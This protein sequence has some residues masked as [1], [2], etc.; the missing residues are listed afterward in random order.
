MLAWVVLATFV[1]FNEPGFPRIDVG[2]LPA[3]DE[4]DETRSVPELIDALKP[5]AILVWRHGSAFPADFWPAFMKFLDAGGS[6]LYLGG[7]P[8]TRFVVGEPGSRIVQARSVAGLKALRLNQC[9]R[10]SAA[11]GTRELTADGRDIWPMFG[12]GLETDEFQPGSWVAVLEPRLCETRDFDDEDGT[13]GSRD[14]AL[15]PLVSL[16]RRGEAFSDATLAY[17]IDRLRGRWAG[18]RWTFWLASEP[19]GMLTMKLLTLAAAQAPVD[20]RIDPILG[21]F[22]PDEHP[23]FIV[24]LHLS[25]KSLDD[26]VPVSR[27]RVSVEGDSEEA[28]AERQEIE[29]RGR[30]A[31]AQIPVGVALR[32]GLAHVSAVLDGK[33]VAHTAFWVFD[34][35]LFESGDK[36]EFDNYTLRRS[37]KPEPIIGTTVMSQTVHRKFLF[38]PN[39]AVWDDTFRELAELKINMV[40]TGVWTGYRKISLDPGVVDESF[41]RALEAYYLSARKHGIP[42]MFTFFAFVPPAFGGENP[43]FDPRAIEGQRAYVAAIAGRFAGAKEIMWDLINEPSFSSPKHLWK[44]RPN[45][46]EF[47]KRAFLAWLEKK[48][49]PPLGAAGSERPGSG[50][51]SEPGAPST[52]VTSNRPAVA[53]PPVSSPISNGTP[54]LGAAGSE[55][56]G[57]GGLSEPGAPSTGVTSNRPAVASPPVSSPISNGTPPLG[58]AGSERPGSGGLSEPGAPSTGVTS[59]RPAVASPPVSSPISNGTPPLGAAGS[60][61]PGSGGL[62]EPGAPSTGVTSNRPAV[63]SPP[64][65]SPIS[66]GTPPLGAAGSER[67]G[68]GGLSEPGA[69]STGVTSNRP[70]VASP[71]V[72]SPTSNIT[73]PLGAAGSDRLRSDSTS[74]NRTVGWEDEVR[75]RW[76]LAPGEPIGLPTPD[77]FEDR[78]VF[79]DNHPYR[80]ADYVWF[81]Q[82]A[83]ADWCRQMTAAIRD[84]GSIAPITVGQDEGGL[85]QRPGPLFHHEAVDFTSMHTWWNNDALLWDAVAAKARGKALIVSETGVMQRELLSG[86][87]LRQ[88]EDSARLLSRKLALAFAGGAG[89]VIQ[90]CYDV[91]PYM[92]SDN[93]VAIGLRRVDGSYKPEHRVLRD[94][95][96]FV[97][98]NKQ[99]FDAPQE[100]RIAIVIPTAEQFS[101]RDDATRAT[102]RAADLLVREMGQNVRLVPEPRLA[103]DLDSP[104]VVVLPACRGI[105]EAGWTAILT[106]ARRGAR[107][108]CSGWFETDEVGRPARRLGLGPP[109]LIGQTHGVPYVAG[110]PFG[111]RWYPLAT[112]E[113]WFVPPENTPVTGRW[114]LGEPGLDVYHTREPIEWANLNA[115]QMVAYWDAI[116][117]AGLK[118]GRPPPAGVGV[119]RVEFAAATLLVAVNESDGVAHVEAESQGGELELRPG[120]ARLAILERESGRIIDATSP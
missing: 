116:A 15:V 19:P 78:N 54:P 119:Y 117:A 47:E 2:E 45:G 10:V 29:L 16:L 20:L 82:E 5:D 18:G 66:N 46:D 76:R 27:I 105:S 112:M 62:S 40:R 53:S 65:S 56:P 73:P 26:S 94:F 107:V 32:P 72:S 13:A 83:F 43:Y 68:S 57:S 6:F 70:A 113:S 50:G 44:C 84:A 37:G 39:A 48:F 99:Y 3:I 28:A 69:P 11:G 104:D 8:F 80:A 81:A 100:P 115:S 92:A 93:E 52:G 118:I 77:D 30:T 7:E 55:R 97:A 87:A 71:P 25:R 79:G 114:N 101:P 106:A 61:R 35:A 58:A 34:A 85:T 22:R 88:P 103:E 98:R 75:S 23:S 41:L 33:R 21:C 1:T 86:E 74:A 59:N 42:V 110:S 91:N 64:V 96:A 17:S 67:P 49:T 63:A 24:R 120:M 102:R 38:E 90:W 14:A 111:A 89:G 4:A 12:R 60:E 108:I 109:Q 36:L 51:L 31:S 95:A 9:Y